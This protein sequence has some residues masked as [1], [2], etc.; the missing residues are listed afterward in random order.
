[1]NK[2][3][4]KKVTA[5]VLSAA[6]LATLGSTALLG[7]C[8]KTAEINISGSS[9]VS[10]LMLNLAAEYEKTHDVSIIVTTSDSSTGITEAKEGK[11]DLGMAS[12]AVSDDALTTV[13]IATDGVAIIANNA[14]EITDVTPEEVYELYANG[15][16]I[17]GKIVAAV[18]REAGSG[19]YDAFGDLIKNAEG[20]K[21]KSLSAFASC[22]S[23]QN[24]TLSVKTAISSNTAAN[25]IGYISM[26]S[27]DDTVKAL[28]VKGVAAT[29]EN[30][31][32]GTYSLSRPFNVVYNTEKGLSPEVKA[33]LDFILSDAGQK[34]VS[35]SG[36]VDVK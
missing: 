3:K 9:S 25:T 4:N 21:L 7:G 18:S 22:V 12:K 1:M 31:K 28:M 11:N 10:P 27:I 34:I 36:Y 32:N 14:C 24:A 13:Q 30:V 33:F 26:G 16:P 5:I 6:M 29:A 8:S 2:T 20:K 15:T 17:Q 19:T 23:V 35:E